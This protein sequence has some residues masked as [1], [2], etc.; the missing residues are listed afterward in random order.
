VDFAV[1][2][3]TPDDVGASIDD[4]E[5]LR[6]RARQNVVLE[7]GLFVGAIGRKRVCA[8]HK[9]NVELPSDFDGVLYVPMDD[10]AGWHLK[11]A[12][13]LRQSG[14]EVDLNKAM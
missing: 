9:G 2:I 4:S 7:L 10:A 14:L 13:E 6:Q 8:L 1:I 5:N 12:K 3:L 11:L